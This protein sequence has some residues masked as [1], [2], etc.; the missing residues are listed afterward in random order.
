MTEREGCADDFGQKKRACEA[1]TST[2]TE[3]KTV[4]KDSI[5]QPAA[6][7]KGEHLEAC[8]KEWPSCLCNSCARDS[9]SCCIDRTDAVR[10]FYLDYVCC[11]VEC[12]GYRRDTEER[13]PTDGIL[14]CAQDDRK[15]ERE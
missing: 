2:G 12:P 7:R 4:C 15:G 8:V 6:P 9:G 13:S 5:S 10:L 14:R 11:V 3:V 1:D